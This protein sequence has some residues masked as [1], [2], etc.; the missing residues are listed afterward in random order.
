MNTHAIIPLVSLI[1]YIP[2]MLVTLRRP[3]IRLYRSFAFYLLGTMLWSFSSFGAHAPLNKDHTV[4][5][6]IFINL[7]FLLVVATY[8]HFVRAF[9][10]KPNGIRVPL[11]Y[12]FVVIMGL[13]MGFQVLR[14]E[15]HTGAEGGLFVSYGYVLHIHGLF[16]FI[17]VGSAAYALVQRFRQLSDPLDRR[18]IGYLLFGLGVVFLGSIT[19]FS[20]SLG[21]YPV[22][23]FANMVNAL[24]IF[25]AVIKYQLLDIR[26]VIQRGLAYSVVTVGMTTGYLFL[27]FFM[28]R[29]FTNWPSYSSLSVAA[30]LALLFA[31]LFQPLRNLIQ[32]GV[33]RMFYGRTYDY[34]QILLSFHQR[35]SN[36]LNL[37]EVAENMLYPI[38][39]ALDTKRVF[40][41]LPEG[42]GGDFVSRFVQPYS[43]KWPS[44]LLRLTRD[45]PI[46]TSIAVEGK[47]LYRETIDIEPQFKG[48]WEAEK[49]EMDA[50]ELALFCPIRRKGNLIGILALSRKQQS[51]PY[52]HEDVDLLSTMASEAAIV[53]EN[54][55]M[56]ENLKEQQRHV[57]QLFAKTVLA[58]EDE[59]KRISIELHDSVAQWLVGAS[60]R[61][62]TC[63][64]ILN[65]S[66]KG[67]AHA[68]LVEIEETIDR[69]LKEIRRVMLG[70]HPPALDEL[71]LVHSLRQLLEGLKP[72]GIAYH[73][74]STGDAIRLP[75][76]AELTIYRVVQEALNNVRK[77]SG[78]T[79]V[80]LRVRFDPEG[81]SVE[82]RDNGRGFN[83]A[84]TTKGAVA[85]G[86]MGLLGMKERAIM[87]RGNLKIRTR[88]GNG[89]HIILTLPLSLLTSQGPGNTGAQTS[90]GPLKEPE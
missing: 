85:V 70:L 44:A 4:I 75:A 30:S 48:L 37:S 11:T 18:R 12:I 73:F 28:Q 51:R 19:N 63:G 65:D 7:F 16:G 22:D 83:L 57:E 25:Y 8:H 59:R 1:A 40:L 79:A 74:E 71:G 24:I 5:W 29:T 42:E 67:E 89:T 46:V 20:K 17:V 69:S 13:L 88:Q 81:V 2:L 52:S 49:E 3:R 38:V 90:A 33:D 60:Y 27:L 15:A 9:L 61:L 78:A 50:L 56:L 82:I 72:D 21:I 47:A 10:N 53:M 35:M 68:E 14:L 54:A 41:L 31:I 6:V 39:K 55:I 87:L 23:H 43:T 26:V 77:H 84:R 66:E 80:V 58:Q 62:Q 45:N 86:H 64:A 36:V 76:S 34:R 32:Q